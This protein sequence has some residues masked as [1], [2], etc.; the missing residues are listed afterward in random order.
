MDI[1]K[2]NPQ[3]YVILPIVHSDIWAMYKQSEAAFWTAEEID[4][5]RDYQEFV[6]LKDPE[7]HFILTILAFFAA[8]DGIVTENL[9]ARF[10]NDV[11]IP[12]ARAFYAFQSAMENIHNETYSLLIDTLVKDSAA[13]TDL[14]EA[15]QSH[16]TIG[17]K[18]AWAMRH[19][20]SSASFDER[21]VA[22]ACVEGIFFSSSF[23]ALYWLK[24]RGI[25][26]GTTFSNEL[27]SRDEG[28]HTDFACLMHSK[29]SEEQK[30]G[31]EQVE[32]IIREAVA[33]EQDFVRS[34]LPEPILGINATDMCNYVEFVADRLAMALK[35]KSIFNTENPLLF[36]EQI[37]LQGKTNFFEKRVGEYAKTNV[38][39]SLS[40]AQAHCISFDE[41]F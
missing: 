39:G 6:A 26:P 35:I 11:Q 30:I 8:S 21:L 29:L 16:P 12:E 1:L 25:M 19:I 37:S 38:G 32:S 13:K 15:V 4:L 24:K 14:F 17:A 27:I 34:S 9:C 31:A 5:S 3:R 20:Q 2:P 23:A 22:F 28:L 7:Q 41:E 36:M 40:H 18:A 33:L 10:I